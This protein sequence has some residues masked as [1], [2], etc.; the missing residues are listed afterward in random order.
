MTPALPRPVARR[1]ASRGVAALTVVMVLFFVMAMVAAYTNR[2]LLFEQRI[3]ANSYRATRALE[4]AD[5]GVEWTLAMLNGGRITA[6]CTRPLAAGAAG[7]TDFRSRYLT[8]S[9]SEAF[10]EGAFDLAWGQV[11]ANRVYPVCVV[12]NAT[13]RCTCPTVGDADNFAA[14]ADEA[15]SSTFRITF[16]LFNDD[17][18]RGGAIQFVTRGCANPGS[19]NTACIRQTD[20]QP[21]VDSATALITTVG[22]VRALPVAPKA[23]LTVGTTINGTPGQPPADLWVGNGDF[24]SGVTVHAGTSVNVSA[25]PTS[26]FESPA[27]TGGDGRINSDAA[28]QSLSGQGAEAWF[29]AQFVLDRAG[30]RRQPAAVLLNCAAGCNGAAIADALLL[31]PRNPIWAEGDVNLNAAGALGSAADPA[32]LIVNGTLTI[33]GDVQATG[34]VHAEQ[35]RWS[36]P[37]T[38]SWDGA[39][40]S[41]TSFDASSLARLT[42]NKAALDVIRLRY[43]SFVRAPGGWNLF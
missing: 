24:A 3:S 26:R 15:N 5:A 33:S 8:P 16:R 28:L 17:T 43:G 2:N 4:A 22:L 21:G 42:Y 39:L 41:R 31:N 13:T 37:A 10:G 12:S 25:P 18:P 7:L 20:D 9:A 19:G 1:D 23:V 36:A 30:Y 29:R 27:G 6:D 32:M 11:Q 35:I 40:V 34:F 14:T 38:A